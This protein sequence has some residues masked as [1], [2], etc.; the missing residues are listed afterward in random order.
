VIIWNEPLKMLNTTDLITINGHC[1]DLNTG[2]VAEARDWLVDVVNFIVGSVKLVVAEPD[3][4]D[5]LVRSRVEASDLDMRF[6]YA[7]GSNISKEQI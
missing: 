2:F 6:L 1:A 4:W 5:V 3:L 7:R